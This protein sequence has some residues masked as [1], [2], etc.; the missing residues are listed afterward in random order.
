MQRRDLVRQL[1][2]AASGVAALHWLAGCGGNGETA[3]G[4]DAGSCN[5][6]GGGSKQGAVIDAVPIPSGPWWM[7]GNFGPVGDEIESTTLAVV[8]CLPPQL[9][10]TYVRN[11]PNPKTG[12]EKHWFFGDGMLYGV[13]LEG[14]KAEWCRNRWVQTGPLRGKTRSQPG[15]PPHVA[16]T[17]PNTSLVR[18]GG[19][20]LALYEAGLPF[21]VTVDLASVGNLDFGGKLDRPISAHPKLDPV[22]G[23]LYF[24]SYTDLPPF[25]YLHRVDKTGKLVSSVEVTGAGPSMQHD[26]ALTETKAVVLDLPVTFDIQLALQGTM[27]FQ[28]NDG[29]KARFGVL[30][31]N[32]DGK[33]VTWI[34]VKPCYV[35]HVLN[36]YDDG[37]KV[38]V[39]GCRSD[40]MWVGG[41]ATMHYQPQLWRWTLDLAAK[42][43]T[44]QQ[45]DDRDFE[46][47]SVASGL[48]GRKHRFGFGQQL[49]PQPPDQTLATGQSNRV[50]KWDGAGG[51]V[52][53]HDL[54]TG[55]QTDEPVFAPAPDGKQGDE[56]WL[57]SFVFD[58]A[59][60]RSELL[61]LDAQNVKPVARVLLPRRVPFGCHGIWLG[62]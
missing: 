4:A 51:K 20:V 22:T 36:A 55:R 7:Q 19:K 16:D 45:L 50:L 61:V 24:H 10:G 40:K 25:V 1:S 56:G 53:A 35:F 38:V 13:R 60:N 33:D 5:T 52:T 57:V 27:P 6:D 31:R 29:Y 12:A 14:G 49:P 46:F 30:D 2:Q 39:E 3:T 8:G 43:A 28:W 32:G 21:E 9:N 42:T 41:P 18:H 54:G 48:V 62:A 11:G 58:Y 23:E 26:M 17:R 15:L 44:E 47:P 59:Q 34:E 37:G